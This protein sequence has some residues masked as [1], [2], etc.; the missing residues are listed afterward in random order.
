MSLFKIQ[1]QKYSSWR[2][3]FGYRRKSKRARDHHDIQFLYIALFSIQAVIDVTLDVKSSEKSSWVGIGDSYRTEM[4]WCE[5][6]SEKLFCDDAHTKPHRTTPMHQEK[7]Q[8]FFLSISCWWLDVKER[9]PQN[10]TIISCIF[11]FRS[12][13]FSQCRVCV[14]GQQLKRLSVCFFKVLAWTNQNYISL[15]F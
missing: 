7:W 10:L 12:R 5:K 11:Q 2:P 9:P 1:A 8:I 4:S 6:F 14:T 13:K 15:F 3:F